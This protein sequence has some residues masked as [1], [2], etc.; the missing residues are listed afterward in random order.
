[1]GRETRPRGPGDQCRCGPKLSRRI[2]RLKHRLKVKALR[3]EPRVA[4][5]S[6]DS[7][8][9]SLNCGAI[10]RIFPRSPNFYEGTIVVPKTRILVGQENQDKQHKNRIIFHCVSEA[11]MGG[12]ETSKKGNSLRLSPLI[13]WYIGADFPIAHHGP[14]PNGQWSEWYDQWSGRGWQWCPRLWG[15]CR[16][17]QT[18]D[19]QSRWPGEWT[20]GGLQKVL[21]Q[22]CTVLDFP[23]KMYHYKKLKIP[24]FKKGS[25]RMPK[26]LS[27]SRNCDTSWLIYP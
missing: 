13:G 17:H 19:A 4:V 1:M 8:I 18:L 25:I 23:G 12:G 11:K 10:S 15:V 5:T 16:L 27:V 14:E 9:R 6:T 22:S 3:I 2:G 21:H 26:D 20:S 24:F 7:M